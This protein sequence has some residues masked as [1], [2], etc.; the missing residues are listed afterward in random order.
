MKKNQR[1]FGLLETLISVGVV[2]VITYAVINQADLVGKIR[3]R[4]EFSERIAEITSSIKLALGDTQTCSS[5]VNG[6]TIGTFQTIPGNSPISTTVYNPSAGLA[7]G[8]EIEARNLS[9][10]FQ[11]VPGPNT[12]GSNPNGSYIP[13]PILIRVHLNIK[14]LMES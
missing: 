3:G 12:S 1:G 7:I 2:S 8:G 13:A 5:F 9:S 10:P 6:I 11:M 4:G 14:K